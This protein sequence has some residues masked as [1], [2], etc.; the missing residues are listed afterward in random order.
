M[1]AGADFVPT[2][3]RFEPGSADYD[4]DWNNLGPNVGFA[5]RPNVQ[6][7]WLRSLLGD[8]EQATI[9]AAATR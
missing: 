5:W 6:Q 3:Q 4:T 9:C 7:G 8:P 1:P 2:Y